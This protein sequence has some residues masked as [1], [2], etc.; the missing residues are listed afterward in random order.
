MRATVGDQIVVHGR[1]AER[2][3]Q[4][5]EVLEVHGD[6]GAPPYV[7]KFADGHSG[8]IFPGPDCVIRP[9]QSPE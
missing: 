1:T 2:A 9:R 7:V 3:D 6:E 5:G 4:V 8:L